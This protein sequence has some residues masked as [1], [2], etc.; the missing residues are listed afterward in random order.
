MKS[1]K[2]H[3]KLCLVTNQLNQ[4]IIEYSK[5]IELA[6]SGG[7]SMV[8]LRDK[9]RSYNELKTI[10]LHLKELLLPFKIPLIINDHVELTMEVDA[11]GVH[12]G[13]EDMDIIKARKILG[14]NKIIGLS[15]EDLSE[16][17]AFNKLK[18]K[19]YAAASAVFTSNSKSN[20]KKTWGIKG[21]RDLVINSSHPVIAIGNINQNN[22]QSIIR[23]GAA[24]AAV[25]SSIHDSEPFKSTH[26]LCIKI[27]N[28]YA[29]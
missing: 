29:K 14:P 20:C 23:T 12:L 17:K 25:I 10:A 16:L 9:F 28:C 19:Y 24:G 11:D 6:I 1:I 21:L 5:L 2:K 3:L 18:G 15:I 26:N 22:I 4:D 27:E 7:V 8:Q 13:S